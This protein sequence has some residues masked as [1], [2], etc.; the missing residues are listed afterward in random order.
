MKTLTLK[1]LYDLCQEFD[2]KHGRWP[3]HMFEGDEVYRFIEEKLKSEVVND[4]QHEN[5]ENKQER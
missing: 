2:R 1:E 3:E 4:K 5:C